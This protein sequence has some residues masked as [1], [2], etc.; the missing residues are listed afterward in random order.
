MSAASFVFHASQGFDPKSSMLEVDKNHSETVLKFSVFATALNRRPV[1]SLF[2]SK[3]VAL[4][5]ARVRQI[6]ETPHALESLG[7]SP[8]DFFWM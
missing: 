3:I 1:R 5:S 4:F 8:E 2:Y 7:Q 6:P